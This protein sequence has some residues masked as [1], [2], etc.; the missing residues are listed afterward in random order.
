MT[1]TGVNAADR[2][3]SEVS[4]RAQGGMQCAAIQIGVMPSQLVATVVIRDKGM[5][6][7][8]LGTAL[9]PLAAAYDRVDEELKRNWV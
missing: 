9:A 6:Q 1:G 7:Y 8:V 3:T 5:N 4:I 2:L